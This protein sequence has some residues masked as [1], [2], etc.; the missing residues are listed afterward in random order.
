[1]MVAPNTTNDIDI[2]ILN[3][4]VMNDDVVNEVKVKGKI[5][6]R[7]KKNTHFMMVMESYFSMSGLISTRYRA[8]DVA[9]MKMRRFPI[10]VVDLKSP[11]PAD[12]IT[13][14]APAAP[15]I[16]PETL[17]VVIFSFRI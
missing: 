10:I 13:I 9:L 11:L 8:H 14:R 6:I 16:I 4:I 1:M 17:M 2:Q 7:P 12:R 3:G 5:I 15:S